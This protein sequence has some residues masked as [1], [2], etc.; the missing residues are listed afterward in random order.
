MEPQALT[1]PAKELRVGDVL[2]SLPKDV[3]EP[4]LITGVEVSSQLVK[5]LFLGGST[6]GYDP[7]T[8]VRVLR[9]S[10]ATRFDRV[11]K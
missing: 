9:E 4:R 1:F 8:L 10:P 5:V 3:I 2:F 11:L 7:E 6:L